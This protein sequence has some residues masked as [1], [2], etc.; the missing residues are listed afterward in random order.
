MEQLGQHH[1]FNPP[2]CPFK[3]TAGGI[4]NL[5]LFVNGNAFKYGFVRYRADPTYNKVDSKH[6]MP[7]NITSSTIHL[8]IVEYPHEHRVY[9]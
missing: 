8:F 6:P 9:L 7:V 2:G 3:K 4:F 5:E 1:I